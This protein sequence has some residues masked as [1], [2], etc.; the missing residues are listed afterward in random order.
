MSTTVYTLYEGHYSFGV[1]ALLNSLL[2]KGFIGTYAVAYRGK[3]PGWV[4][5]LK[6]EGPEEYSISG[7][8]VKFIPL[9]PPLHLRFYKSS[10][11]LELFEKYLPETQNLFY[12][13][14]DIVIKGDWKFYEGWAQNGI[15]LCLDNA[16][17]IMPADHPWRAEWSR[18]GGRLGLPV[19]RQ[20][21][22]YYNS[23]FFG[24]TRANQDFLR[25]WRDLTY[26]YR[27]MGGDVIG[28]KGQNR[29]YGVVGDQDLMNA[30]IMFSEQPLSCI[31]PEG[32]DFNG[33]G[34]YVMSHAVYLIKPWVK[35]FT[36]DLLKTGNAPSLAD[37][38]F[39]K[40]IAAP[41]RLYSPMEERL[42][43][44]NIKVAA[45]LGRVV[46]H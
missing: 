14:P 11:G 27:D 25:L 18:I 40:N 37:K 29:Y 22:F 41:I 24:M 23:G 33:F 7:V 8:R 16:Y 39:M 12:F 13:D 19:I 3:L 26:A 44:V 10:L 30:A 2:N 42:K 1:G 38:E 45:A 20:Q 46:G 4:N 21:N 15:A 5:Q 17:G 35:N 34:G 36:L 31:G 43:R 6:Q 32:M 28:S 9:N